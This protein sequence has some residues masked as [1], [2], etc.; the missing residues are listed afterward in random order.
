M[1]GG[2]ERPG[3]K[4]GAFEYPVRHSTVCHRGPNKTQLLSKRFLRRPFRPSFDIVGSTGL[5]IILAWPLSILKNGRRT[6]RHRPPLSLTSQG[7]VPEEQKALGE[8]LKSAANGGS[9]RGGLS[10]VKVG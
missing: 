3:T 2:T 6:H 5:T 8:F 4:G 9:G 1:T 10:P 7:A